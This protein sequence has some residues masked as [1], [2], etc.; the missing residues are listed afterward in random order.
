[1]N[2]NLTKVVPYKLSERLLQPG[3]IC[4]DW[5]ESVW[6]PIPVIEYFKQNPFEDFNNYPDPSNKV[7][8]QRLAEYTGVSEDYIET[9]NGSDSALDYTF[10]ALINQG[11]VVLIPY[12]NYTQ[13]D[14]TI[15]S[16]GASIEHCSV[17]DLHLK[18]QQEH[19]KFVYL[20]N[21]NNPI[22]YVLDDIE[23]IVSQNPNTHFIVDEAYSEFA[24]TYSVFKKAKEY[25]NLI[26][27][28]TFS[29]ALGLASLRLG[30][31][32]ANSN[33]LECIRKIKNF[34]EVNRMAEVAGVV[35]LDNIDWYRE[36]VAEMESNKQLFIELV[37]IQYFPYKS[38]AN[39]VLLIH[40]KAQDILKEAERNGILVRDRSAFIN[41]SIRI[42]VGDKNHMTKLAHLINNI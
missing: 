12:P 8:K 42:T 25:P 18:C 7:L 34:K 5:N 38:Y 23:L 39:F 28:R 11:D 6:K 21:P 9:F 3:M 41:N 30:Y 13:V 26:V 2:V 33:T 15:L 22:G 4:L 36:R 17:A 37:G 31:L 20:S 1:M 14:Q 35:V 24:D 40:P 32:T 16:L 19:I 29:K 27:T 10:R